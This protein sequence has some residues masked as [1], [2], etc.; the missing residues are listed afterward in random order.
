MMQYSVYAVLGDDSWSWHGEIERDDLTSC[1]EVMV[2]LRARK[3]EMRGDVGNHH[4]K[5]GLTRISYASQFTIPNMAGMSPD[6]AHNITDTRS[7]NLNQASHTPYFSYPLVSSISFPSS[8]PISLFLVHN[9]TIIAEHKV[10]SYLCMSQ[11]HDHELT[12]SCSIYWVQHTP[13]AAYTMCSI[14][15]VQYTLQIVSRPFILT[16]T[17]WPL[18]VALTSSVPPC[19]DRLPPASSA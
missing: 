10:A 2:E 6:P 14:H 16:I 4:G 17:C 5:L 7:S 12:P 3:R 13:S 9:S 15:G 11:C 18:N 8:S 1:S 19:T